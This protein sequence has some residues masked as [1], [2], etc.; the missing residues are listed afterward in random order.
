L[1][2]ISKKFGQ[3]EKELN[4][5]VNNSVE[6]AATFGLEEARRRVPKDT[7]GTFSGIRKFVFDNQGFIVSEQ[8]VDDV[9]HQGQ[10]IQLN[11]LLEEGNLR[12]L[13]W[14]RRTEPKSGEFHFMENTI[15]PTK[16]ELINVLQLNIERI[17]K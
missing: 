10:R 7:L 8:V 11:Q 1:K 14:G 3:L 17:L 6:D 5:A 15:E 16:Q 12:E 9:N 2:E 4:S 13:E